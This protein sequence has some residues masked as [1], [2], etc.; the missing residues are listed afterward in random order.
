MSRWNG[1]HGGQEEG[2]DRALVQA[3]QEEEDTEATARE[4][5][6][7]F[8]QEAKSQVPDL[9]IEEG[10]YKWRFSGSGTPSRVG[11]EGDSRTDDSRE[12]EVRKGRFGQ[13]S[14]RRMH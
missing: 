3:I 13:D 11:S 10:D 2:N 8:Q 1:V 4:W 6:S 5:I 14:R 12:E 7:F 9:I